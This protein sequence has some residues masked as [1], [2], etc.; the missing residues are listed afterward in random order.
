M[1]IESTAHLPISLA[2]LD[3]VFHSPTGDAL[4]SRGADLP[5]PR[6]GPA[7]VTLTML[8]GTSRA[9]AAISIR[10]VTKP[11]NYAPL[12]TRQR[13]PSCFGALTHELTGPASVRSPG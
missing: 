10:E 3:G 5:R 1:L 2:F 8:D 4:P 7:M 12:I 6:S 13:G 9:G 11:M